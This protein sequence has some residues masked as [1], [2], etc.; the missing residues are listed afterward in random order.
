M[1]I[2]VLNEELLRIVQDSTQ[3]HHSSSDPITKSQGILFCHPNNM[4]LLVQHSV[5]VPITSCHAGTLTFLQ[6]HPDMGGIDTSLGMHSR[7][8]KDI[9]KS[10]KVRH[11]SRG[12]LFIVRP[13]GHIDLHKPIYQ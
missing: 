8:K 5:I 1:E 9:G 2:G 6:E 7:C 10:K 11:W 4:Q 13:C 12:H 3:T